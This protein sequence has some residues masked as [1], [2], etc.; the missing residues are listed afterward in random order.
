MLESNSS[1]TRGMI[2]EIQRF[3]IHDGPGIR[4]TV[5]LKGCPLH[6]LWCHNPEGQS[7][8]QQLSY[9]PAKCIACGSCAAACPYGAHRMVNGVHLFDRSLCQLDGACAR[10]CWPQA[11]EMVGKQVTV[12]EVMAE[13]LRDLPFYQNSGG[14]ITL[15]G[16]EPL[17]Q[18]LFSR[19][20]LGSARKYG[21]HT[22]VET[23]GFA[24]YGAFKEILSSVDLFLYDI[25]DMNN[26]RHM[27]FTGKPNTTIL[28]NLRQ[29][30]DA[31]AQIILRLPLIP[32]YND[33]SDHFSALAELVKSLPHLAG[34]EIMPYHRLGSSKHERF[35]TVPTIPAEI[36]AAEPSVVAEWVNTLA[37]LGVTTL[38]QTA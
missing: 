10:E 4:T 35:G 31:G 9:L 25:K 20:L 14:G 26:Q 6:C 17:A 21:L 27:E 28:A 24:P 15:S 23:C 30:H 11:L 16:G 34:V 36:L 3:S 1:T 7:P 38:N 37:E 18:L 32:G 12:E 8:N 19:D 13:V 2:F 22:A 29:L 33:Q 5:F